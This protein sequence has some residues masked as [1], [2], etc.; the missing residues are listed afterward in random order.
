VTEAAARSGRRTKQNS[1]VSAGCHG[2]R[3]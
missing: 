1:K 3:Q 2:R